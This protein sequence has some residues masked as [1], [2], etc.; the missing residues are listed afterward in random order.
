MNKAVAEI[1]SHLPP[2]TP[3]TDAYSRSAVEINLPYVQKCVKESFRLT[4]AFTMPL[5]RR[6]TDIEGLILDGNVL[7][8]GVS[9][10]SPCITIFD[11]VLTKVY[12]IRPLLLC[13]TT[14][15]TIVRTFGETIITFSGLRGG[16]MR[17]IMSWGSY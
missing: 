11:A 10:K 13:A 17:Q 2:M 1:D 14:R 8:V 5:A 7:P 12:E 4:P 16:K 6:V 3:G 15:S 9:Q